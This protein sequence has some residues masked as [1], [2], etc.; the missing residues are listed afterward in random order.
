V[1]SAVGSTS[2]TYEIKRLVKIASDNK[3]HKVS[4]NELPYNIEFQYIVLPS[5]GPHAY[6]KAKGVN[7][8]NY[9]LL[10]GQMNVFIDEHFITTSKLQQTVP[11]DKMNMYL[12]IDPGIKVSI[13]PVCKQQTSTGFL[14]LKK[15]NQTW[16]KTTRIQNN[17]NFDVTVLVYQPCPFSRDGNKSIVVKRDEPLLAVHKN[18][19]L[20][21]SSILCWT[22][23]IPAGE[24][25]KTKLKY[26]IE[27]PSEN[28]IALIKQ[29]AHSF[30]NY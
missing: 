30:T 19:E 13:K 8:S 9:K 6:L 11:G 5:R 29:D 2:V 25:K 15:N 17:K 27:Y 22:L 20:D 4:I 23:A 1:R 21:S 16:S 7:N 26:T 3:P 28:E 10:E 14:V 18:V 24:F 12:G